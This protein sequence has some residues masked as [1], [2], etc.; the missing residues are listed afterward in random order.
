MKLYL[1]YILA[2]SLVLNPLLGW[3]AS[4][5]SLDAK[6]SEIT[7]SIATIPQV[8]ESLNQD[9]NAAGGPITKSVA[10]TIFTRLSAAVRL[11]SE[12][13]V[14]KSIGEE[15]REKYMMDLGGQIGQLLITA[16][17]HQGEDK[18]SIEDKITNLTIGKSVLREYLLDAKAVFGIQRS[19]NDEYQ[20]GVMQRIQREK[21][22]PEL[23]AELQEF[24]KKALPQMDPDSPLRLGT[25]DFWKEDVLDKVI[26]IRENRLT[27]QYVTA[28][29][30]LGLGL[31][32]FFAPTID[33]VGFFDGRSEYSLFDSSV[34][35]LSVWTT[36]A[37]LKVQSFSSKTLK[38]LRE[39]VRIL[40][41]P[42]ETV[43]SF[44]G[45]GAKVL[46]CRDL[47]AGA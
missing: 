21:L 5:S 47:F 34:L 3:S 16:I 4:K 1:N 36:I 42:G 28:A 38:S 9:D 22:S 11:M 39:L 27:A 24:A 12:V 20:W 15:D 35:Y 31:F 17:R 23:I 14:D 46:M 18:L 25:R 30:Y 33:V 13:A 10:K 44:K 6:V 45:S 26:K 37:L 8:V 29:T 32:S 7:Y 2:V 41:N 40:D 43:K 19:A